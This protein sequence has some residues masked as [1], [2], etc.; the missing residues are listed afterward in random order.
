MS[1][2]LNQIKC[3]SW[4]KIHI[5]TPASYRIPLPWL[6]CPVKIP[7]RENNITE[8][9]AYGCREDHLL[10]VFFQSLCKAIFHCQIYEYACFGW[11]WA[12]AQLSTVVI[13]Q[14]LLG[15]AFLLDTQRL[16][17]KRKCSP[18]H[19]LLLLKSAPLGDVRKKNC[20]PVNALWKVLTVSISVLTSSICFF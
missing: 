7:G 20:H 14:L 10:R 1:Q 8:T 16:A 5:Y 15:I 18:Y 17:E 11:G 3:H 9:T 6:R 12:T 4:R 19:F 2:K 13:N